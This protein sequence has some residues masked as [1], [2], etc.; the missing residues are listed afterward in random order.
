MKLLKTISW[1][2]VI[3]L[4]LTLG[5]APYTPEPHV[6]Q[7]L[8]MLLAGTLSKPVDIFDFVLH[9]VPWLLLVLKVV[10]G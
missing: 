4:C 9:G 7:K 2:V 8:Q 3:I 10:R 6:W 1:P 5:L